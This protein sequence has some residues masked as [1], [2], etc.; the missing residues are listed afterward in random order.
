MESSIPA[1]SPLLLSCSA[2][3]TGSVRRKLPKQVGWTVIYLRLEQETLKFFD[4]D[5]DSE[6]PPALAIDVQQVTVTKVPN[7]SADQPHCIWI[8]DR[9]TNTELMQLACETAEVCGKWEQ[10][11]AVAQGQFTGMQNPLASSPQTAKWT[12]VPPSPQSAAADNQG[13]GVPDA[14]QGLGAPPPPPVGWRKVANAH[15]ADK[16]QRQDEDFLQEKNERVMQKEM[17]LRTLRK[18]VEKQ[19][20]QTKRKEAA[21]LR[22][23]ELRRREHNLEVGRKL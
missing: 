5:A 20:Y 19:T 18:E 3:M 11:L 22:E 17:E 14:W 13:P 21:H 10:A 15:F 2:S 9:R 16:R 8:Q 7:P 1:G 23:M 4:S 6:G 12:P